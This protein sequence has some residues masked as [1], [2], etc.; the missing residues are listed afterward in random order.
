MSTLNLASYRFVALNDLPARRE[1]M[2]Q[3]CTELGL[4][5]IILLAPEGIN[6]FVA[7]SEAACEAFCAW[8]EQDEAT[9]GLDYKRSYSSTVP[10]GKMRVKLKRE[11]I[12]FAQPQID[13]SHYTSPALSP[14]DLKKWL[15]EGKKI[16]LLDTRNH[17]EVMEGTFEG[18]M[19]LNIERFTQ[20]ADA[21]KA[22]PEELK[23]QPVVAFCTGGIRCEKA[24]PYLESL[25]FEQVYQLEGGILRYLELV[26]GEHYKGTCFVF[27]RRYSVDEKLAATQA[28]TRRGEQSSAQS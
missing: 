15:D 10:F 12:T 25:G 19:E 9:A 28:I 21:A 16:T 7:G 4:K 20:F 17:F 13:P 27:D 8:M 24:A 11:I 2:Q 1:R 23:K 14:H 6:L 22:L 3:H 5:G 18:A 26:G